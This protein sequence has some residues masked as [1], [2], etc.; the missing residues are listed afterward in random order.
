MTTKI[1]ILPEKQK[2]S[3]LK[4]LL[5]NKNFRN[6]QNY[7]FS[8]FLK[9]KI[10]LKTEIW[11][12]TL[13]SKNWEISNLLP[14]NKYKYINILNIDDILNINIKNYYFKY[15]FSKFIIILITLL[16]L[17]F[18]VIFWFIFW[19]IFIYFFIKWIKEKNELKK[20]LFFL[21]NKNIIIINNNISKFINKKVEF[22]NTKIK[23]NNEKS[24][25][26]NF[27]FNKNMLNNQNYIFWR[28]MKNIV[29][30]WMYLK[31]KYKNVIWFD[32]KKE[33][34]YISYKYITDNVSNSSWW[35]KIFA[36]TFL[37]LFT[38]F[39]LILL[40]SIFWFY[41]LFIEFI[42]LSL[43]IYFL[44]FYKYKFNW[45]WD[46]KVI[47]DKDLIYFIKK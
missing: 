36:T 16:L 12:L 33:F 26:K 3:E 9:K 38:L 37:I 31:E 45:F 15:Y 24:D 34:Q 5:K 6:N 43:A 27:I 29:K 10:K 30:Y 20:I 23:V 18:L 25:L 2:K 13:I 28:K 7:I 14:F 17:H 19:L 41:W 46:F 21:D 47:Y 44:Y 40:I 32:E 35:L 39:S 8:S 42:L 11:I 4:E 1:K 22:L